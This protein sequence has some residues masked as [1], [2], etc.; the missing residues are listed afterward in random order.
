MADTKEATLQARCKR[1]PARHA[2]ATEGGPRRLNLLV[3]KDAKEWPTNCAEQPHV[4]EV[5]KKVHRDRAVM[6]AVSNRN[7]LGM[8]GQ[9]VDTVQKV[10]VPNFLV[11]ALDQQTSDFLQKRNAPH[12]VRALRSRSGSTDNH[13][14]SGL[15]FKILS[16]LLS[17]GVSVLLTDVDVVLTQVTPRRDPTLTPHWGPT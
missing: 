16:E 7:I 8:L 5:V 4:C 15:K 2:P 14:T 11:V 17:V 10:G 9:F 12:Y 6:A 1:L 3:D 13:A